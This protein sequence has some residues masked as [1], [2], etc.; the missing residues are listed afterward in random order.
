[1]R[2]IVVI[3]GKGGTGKTTVCAAF[4]HLAESAVICDL[5]VDVPDLHIVLDPRVEREEVFISGHTAEIVQ[6]LCVQCGR[7]ADL[8][9]FG[10]VRNEDGHFV[11]DPLDCEGC[12]VCRALC[13]ARAIDFPE[14]RCGLW[15]I[16]ETRFGPFVHAQLEPG[17]ENS[18]RLVSLLKQQ[19]RE[20]AAAQGRELLLC[21]G[22][23]GVGCPVISSLAGAS[24]AVAVVE[25]TPSGRHDFER[26]TTLCR[27]FRIPVAVV[28]NKADLNPAEAEA[29]R[30]FAV[31]Q[32]HSLAGEIPFDP[33]ATRA[34]I[35]RRAL[36][37]EDTPLAAVLASIWKRVRALADAMPVRRENLNPVHRG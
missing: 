10:A 30:R 36:T 5:D 8:C 27:H 18:G 4:A 16:S 21:D 19:A 15:R 24:L 6:D 35:R 13:P 37:E 22:S 32:G 17:Q 12:G 20:L 25:P 29:I 31:E 2:E 14:R 9:R 7:C 23:P 34:M 3:S 33:Q 26:V 11:I 28:I 1:M